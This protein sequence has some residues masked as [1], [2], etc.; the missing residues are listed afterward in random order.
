MGSSIYQRKSDKRWVGSI[1][2]G[3]DDLGK[4]KRK[5]VYGDTKKEVEDKVNT[6]LYEIRTG[7]Y[8]EPNKDTLVNF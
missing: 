4:R 8:V 6:I 1:P 3:K 5:V 7:E 2:M